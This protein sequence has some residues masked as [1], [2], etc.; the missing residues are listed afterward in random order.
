MLPALLDQASRFGAA[1]ARGR[2]LTPAGNRT[3]GSGPDHYEIPLE[4]DGRR[5]GSLRIGVTPATV[6]PNDARVLSTLA[7]YAA[8]A[9]ERQR[10]AE[11][12]A[13]VAALRAADELKTALLAAV[14]HDLK[15]PL[16]SMLA[17]LAN[18]RRHGARR[19]AREGDA[20]P[21]REGNAA[22]GRAG[23]RP[24]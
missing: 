22:A 11:E 1:G 10:L 15:T 5:I 8:L 13:A 24:P 9:M 19:A 21:D 20:G 14:S 16:A 17:S 18:L 7:S 12:A 2:S 3:T 6:S 23:E 4:V